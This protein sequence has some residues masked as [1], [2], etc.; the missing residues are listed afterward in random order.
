MGSADVGDDA[1][2]WSG[3]G[4]QVP[5]GDRRQLET[6]WLGNVDHPA[7][8]DVALEGAP[9]LLLQVGPCDGGDRRE[10]AV[11]VVHRAV[12]PFSSPIPRE[13]SGRLW[14]SGAGSASATVPTGMLSRRIF[15]SVPSG[16]TIVVR[17]TC[18]SGGWTA[19]SSS[20]SDSFVRPITFSWSS[21]GIAFH[22]C[23]SWMYFCTIT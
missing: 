1:L 15:R 19:S 18:E 17:A 22:A 21:T 20:I 16:S 13:S 9:C 6:A 3:D 14:T 5:G 2:G 12:L 11:Q 8:G 4:V 7:A 23:R 10:F